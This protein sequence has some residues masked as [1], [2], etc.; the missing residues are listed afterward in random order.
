VI[1]AGL[2]VSDEP[3]E[4]RRAA[5]LL[6]AYELRFWDALADG[7]D[8]YAP[9]LRR[10]WASRSPASSTARGESLEVPLHGTDHRWQAEPPSGSSSTAG[11]SGSGPSGSSARF[12]ATSLPG[13]TS[14]RCVAH[15][16]VGAGPG[17]VVYPPM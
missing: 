2:D 14:R 16:G 7:V 5:R 10:P 11:P 13:R 3:A 9:G 12:R 4:A 15:A 6:H 8:P 1:Q 17:R